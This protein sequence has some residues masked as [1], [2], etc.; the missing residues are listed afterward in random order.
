MKFE[1]ISF[2]LHICCKESTFCTFEGL[3]RNVGN[4]EQ[5]YIYFQ[6]NTLDISKDLYLVKARHT[7]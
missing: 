1:N 2:T 4:L 6:P 3:Y 5:E 7:S